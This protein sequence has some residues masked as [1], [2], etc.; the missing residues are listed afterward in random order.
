MPLSCAVFGGLPGGFFAALA[1]LGLDF[2][3]V[4]NSMYLG[5]EL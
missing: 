2:S 5:L 3:S 4:G 1:G